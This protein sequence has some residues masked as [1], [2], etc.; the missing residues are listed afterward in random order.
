LISFRLAHRDRC[1]AQG[2]I[3]SSTQALMTL[4]DRGYYLTGTIH[5][6]P[7]TGEA[8]T[9]PSSIDLTYHHRL[10]QGGY[11]AVGIIMTRD[12]YVRFFTSEMPF[13][14]KVIGKDIVKLG[15]NSYRLLLS[16]N[17]DPKI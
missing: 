1:R 5:S 4:C 7:G 13:T 17:S 16:T 3:V 15:H 14:L 11:Q 8:S 10:E 12:G 9:F 2:D 6:H